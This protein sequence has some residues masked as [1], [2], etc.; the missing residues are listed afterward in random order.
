MLFLDGAQAVPDLGR[1]VA[2][3]QRELAQF[4]H[5][6]RDVVV[7]Q[8]VTCSSSSGS[9]SSSCS[10]EAFVHIYGFFILFILVILDWPV[11]P[12]NVVE[13]PFRDVA[14]FPSA[15]AATVAV[16]V[17]LSSFAL[18]V[19]VF[20]I[21]VEKPVSVFGDLLVG[22]LFALA[23]LLPPLLVIGTDVSFVQYLPI[24][25]L[26]LQMILDGRN[27]RP[28]VDRCR[29]RHVTDADASLQRASYVVAIGVVSLPLLFAPLAAAADAAAA[30]AAAAVV[31]LL[32]NLVLS[33][34]TTFVLLV[35]MLGRAMMPVVTVASILLLL[36]VCKSVFSGRRSLGRRPLLVLFPVGSVVVSVVVGGGGRGRRGG[37]RTLVL[38]QFLQ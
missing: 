7:W 27:F 15:G 29:R 2:L 21:F 8:L 23:L 16:V 38:H 22:G 20:K 14:T 19:T 13:L 26:L 28:V 35:T 5:D 9:G 24:L 12:G 25:Y 18:D 32:A 30:A 4:G 34:S 6:S 3:G 1:V 36:R 33:S 37:A 10:T 31:M 11:R 17:V